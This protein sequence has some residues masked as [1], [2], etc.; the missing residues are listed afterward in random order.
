MKIT[1]PRNSVETNRE[2]S[3]EK[4]FMPGRIMH[5]MST[6][7]SKETSSKTNLPFCQRSK[8]PEISMV[9]C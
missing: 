4:K 2:I 6:A 3:G 7:V 5:T 8:N 1:I 9:N